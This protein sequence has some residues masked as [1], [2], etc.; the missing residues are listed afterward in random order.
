MLAKTHR[1]G[2]IALGA[3][4]PLIIQEYI[5]ARLED[6]LIFVSLTMAG[7]AIGSLIPD[8][9]SSTSTVGRKV[10]P[11]SKFISSKFGHRGFTHTIL[12]LIL[13]SYLIFFLGDKLK[14]YLE[15]GTDQN[16]T[17]IFASINSFIVV[18]SCLF[19][20]SSIPNKFRGILAKKNDIY[21]IIILSLSTVFF[22]FNNKEKV[23]TYI[24]VYLLGV[25]L[26]YLSH[27]LLDL[28]T[29]E[30]VPLMG[31]FI[32]LKFKLSPFKTGSFIEG[33]ASFFSFIVIVSSLIKLLN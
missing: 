27:I 6:P 9:D 11:I 19:V 33:V 1:M 22:T 17:L 20:L 10:K 14:L 30:G 7:G 18:T 16:K 4:L 28:F 2:G 13:F 29:K 24:E 25:V 5:G 21:I 8:I 32:K 12:A 31:P 3:V 26:G 23:L 15:S